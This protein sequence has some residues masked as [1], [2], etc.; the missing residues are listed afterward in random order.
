MDTRAREL[1]KSGWLGGCS[2]GSSWGGP[3]AAL[4]CLLW[5]CVSGRVRRFLLPEARI[6]FRGAVE[7]R[8]KKQESEIGRVGGDEAR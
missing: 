4:S 6:R 3:V 5:S 2:D 7:Y 1:V 8:G